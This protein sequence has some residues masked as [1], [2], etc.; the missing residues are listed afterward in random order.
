[1][2]EARPA[3]GGDDVFAGG[4]EMGAR[5]RALDWSSTPLG[6][7]EHWPRSLK[8]CVRIMLTSRQPI[9]V[10]W[11]PGLTYLY[12]DPYKAIIGGKH[13]RAL[14]QPTDVVWR[15]IWDVIGPMLRTALSGVEGTYVEAQLLMME[16]HGYE[17]ETYYT[18]SYSPVP[19][20]EG[21]IGGIIC[22]NTDETQRIV[23]ER[24]MALL[25]E[26]ATRTANART[27]EEAC[28]SAAAALA[29]DPRDLPFALVYLLDADRRT[30]RL[31]A[32]AGVD[33]GHP[34]APET[35][36]VD[37]EA[38][39][40]LGRVAE[41]HETVLVELGERRPPARADGWDRPPHQAAVLPLTPSGETGR[42]GFLVAGLSPFRQLDAGYRG[43]LG[44]AAGQVSAGIAHAEAYHE[45]RRRAEA[46]A[47]L[48]RAKTAFFTNVSHEFRTPLTLMLGPLEELLDAP[49]DALSAGARGELALVHRNT[50]RLLRLVNALLDFSRIEAGRA[51]A[52]FQPT[53]LAAFTAELASTFRSAVERA[54]LRLVVHAPPLAE[55]VWVDREMWEK[56]VLN[57][58][59]NAF[60]FTLRGEI[61]VSLRPAPGAV[62]LEVRDTGAGIPPDELPHV[63]SRFHRVRGTEGRTHEG[64]GIGLALVREL[65]LLHGGETAVESVPGEGS[66]FRAR[67]PTG[68]AH[69]PADRLGGERDGVSTATG[70]A[71][72]V[73][74][75]LRWL[76]PEGDDAERGADGIRADDAPPPAALP[77]A[78]GGARVVLADDNADMRGYVGR[79]LSQQGYRVEAVSNGAEALA[80]ARREPPDLVLSDVMM[81]GM[82]GFEL[83]EAL[84]ADAG[85]REVP[86][87]LLSARAGE[88]A[89][90][91]GARTGADDYLTKPFSARELLARV[92]AQLRMARLR[93]EA[94]AALRESEARFRNMADN[95]PV[96]IWVTGPSG[97]CT[98]LNR[99]WYEFTGQTPE[100]AL[101]FG[102]IEATHPDDQRTAH[103]VFVAAN[104]AR[105]PFQ[106]EYRL[107]RADGRY[108]W[109]ID[110]AAPRRGPAGE[111]LGYV[112]S[113]LDI[114]ERKVMEERLR[115]QT[116]EL[117]M[118]A[119]HL[120]E[121][122][123]ETESINDELRQINDELAQR[124][125]EA[126]AANQAKSSFLATM[127]HELRTPLNAMI[128]Y[129]DLMQMGVPEPIPDTAREQVRRV[130][131]SARHLLQL[132]EEILTF[133][134]LEAGREEVQT[135]PVDLDGLLSE[136][137]AIAEPLAHD[138]GLRFG[139]RRAGG[140]DGVETDPRKLRQI[141]INLVG[142]AVKFTEAGSVELEV[143]GADGV[144]E[145]GVR[146][147]G[148]GIAPRHL[149]SIFEPF[150][151]VETERAR[152]A[153]GTGLGLSVSRRLA[154][155]LGGDLSV[156]STPGEGSAFTLRLPRTPP[157]PSG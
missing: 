151:Q 22:A 37:A 24:Q 100:S 39:W 152:R 56:V 35:V 2:D 99:R 21:G 26:L 32:V 157:E 135:E 103:D 29:T 3:P 137:S 43:F 88:E 18:F 78:H 54:G 111:F 148:V 104:A 60:K 147:T 65:V 25:R 127:S 155:L 153:H 8:T 76:S 49:G 64:T 41:S 129:T 57:F 82:D 13:P 1:M 59:S 10:G 20:D 113:V 156:E 55:P 118:Q 112:G 95:A 121:L 142:N 131:L 139:V 42:A 62:E 7:P 124:T 40:E 66:A 136:V 119:G 120:Q 83:L 27:L 15:E 116:A 6:P 143:R 94:S 52:V 105:E 31:A 106:L 149:E 4:G 74:E 16:R 12:N 128:G 108:R 30:A 93:G 38:P 70:A 5:M 92:D 17:E 141:L 117:E 144:V 9:W 91:E 115:E 51:Q 97:S 110:A 33:P 109:A 123:A 75:A 77:G 86:V 145:F 48:D 23:G 96:M 101:G 114:T 126:E 89:R 50:L 45:E 46:L 47:E 79:L 84:R 11:G 133:S 68:T 98:Y 53:D 67:I 122:Q 107:R 154:R 73:E 58:L 132:I 102:W 138:K 125:R 85:L 44:L 71:P 146:D 34:A 19:N 81:P 63:F 28:D 36:S 134:R 14:G 130:G 61:A 150:T 80:A 87:V 72:F 69:L 140:A 90:I